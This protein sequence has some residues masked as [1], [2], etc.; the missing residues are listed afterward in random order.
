MRASLTLVV[1]MML[2]LAADA[3]AQSTC[4]GEQLVLV[5]GNED[6]FALPSEPT[7]PDANLLAY[8]SGVPRRSFDETGV[9]KITIHT[10]TWDSRPILSALLELHVRCVGTTV[11]L[12]GNDRISLKLRDEVLT[13]G[14]ETWRWTQELGNLAGTVW[15]LGQELVLSLDLSDLPVDL[16]GRTSVVEYLF[17]GNLDVFVDDDTVV[18]FMRLTLCLDSAVRAQARSWGSVKAMYE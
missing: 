12:P 7:D 14:G 17:D 2:A 4:S 6:G 13:E 16:Y 15:N 8:F 3:V 18:D 1:G 11:S 5:A 9:N 10:F